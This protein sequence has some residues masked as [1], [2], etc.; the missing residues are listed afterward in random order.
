MAPE[1]SAKNA[2]QPIENTTQLFAKQIPAKQ[3]ILQWHYRR[4]RE[5]LMGMLEG[6]GLPAMLALILAEP[7]RK[8]LQSQDPCHPS[9]K[10]S[11]NELLGKTFLAEF[12]KQGITGPQPPPAEP[13]II[14]GLMKAR[15][16][17]RV[18]TLV[19]QSRWLRTD[20]HNGLGVFLWTRPEVFLSLKSDPRVPQS[21]RP[22]TAGKWVEVL[23][24]RIAAVRAGYKPATGDRY[25]FKLRRCAL[26]R[27]A[28]ATWRLKRD[29]KIILWCGWC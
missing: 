20:G 4:A 29:G 15:T 18:R 17:R 16:P 12:E 8:A 19:K 2:V 10:E 1:D 13:K 22:T 21:S 27:K 9:L 28:P 7:L 6:S 14:E 3:L 23:A 26:C 24:R 11:P 25:V 5:T